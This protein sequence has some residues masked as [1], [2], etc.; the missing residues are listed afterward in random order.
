MPGLS[1]ERLK[2]R[3]V[4]WETSKKFIIEFIHFGG[5]RGS[6]ALSG[7]G[8]GKKFHDSKTNTLCPHRGVLLLPVQEARVQSHFE[9]HHSQYGQRDWEHHRL[10]D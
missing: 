1:P 2:L 10:Q 8:G 7:A 5:F 4:E 6:A 9:A 3:G